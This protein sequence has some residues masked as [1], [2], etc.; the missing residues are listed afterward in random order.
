[1]AIGWSDL[2]QHL[3]ISVADRLVSAEGIAD[4]ATVCTSWRRAAIAAEKEAYFAAASAGQLLPWLM[5]ICNGKE[6]SSAA[7]VEMDSLEWRETFQLPLPDHV[8]HA[9]TVLSSLGWIF[10]SH[11]DYEARLFHPVTKTEIVPP[12]LSTNNISAGIMKFV[13]SALPSRANP[14]GY[15]AIIIHD[16]E[17]EVL[18]EYG[19]GRIAFWAAGDAAWT[20]LEIKDTPMLEDVHQKFFTDMVYRDGRVFAINVWFEVLIFNIDEKGGEGSDHSRP[21]KVVTVERVLET[22]EIYRWAQPYNDSMVYVAESEGSLLVVQAERPLCSHRPTETVKFRVFE[23]RGLES[24]G[25]SPRR[26][27]SLGGR[28]LFLCHNSTS[29]TVKASDYANCEAD[30]IYFADDFRRLRNSVV[31]DSDVGIF[32]LEDGSSERSFRVGIRGCLF[33]PLWVQPTFSY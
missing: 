1:M 23:W 24:G 20:S 17:I 14:E 4:F 28:A 15:K 30:C 26:V 12:K 25:G 22:E 10:T 16:N 33:P 9:K 27:L 32:R 6:D 31:S 5:T 7:S 3:L 2:P 29:F 13:L 11:S 21:T 8:R 18:R 19:Y